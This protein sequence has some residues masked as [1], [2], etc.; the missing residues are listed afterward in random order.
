MNIVL[1]LL[2][3]LVAGWLAGQL[4]KRRGSGWVEDV[5]VDLL[6]WMRAHSAMLADMVIGVIGS[7]IG[8][9]LLGLLGLTAVG[10]IGSLVSATFGAVILLVLLRSIRRL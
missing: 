5:I 7:M 9:F 10:L 1:F 4:V 3:G 8:G 2:I 6:Q